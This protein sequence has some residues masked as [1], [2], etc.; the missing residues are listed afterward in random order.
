MSTSTGAALIPL[1]VFGVACSQ[2]SPRSSAS[3]ASAGVDSLNARLIQA[4]RDR[5]PQGYAALYTNSAVFERPAFN[6]VRGRAGL[7]A[8]ARSNWESLDDKHLQLTVSS[9]RIAPNH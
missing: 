2:A 5:D 6:T 3:E 9:R 7:K 8:M 1:L 4:Y